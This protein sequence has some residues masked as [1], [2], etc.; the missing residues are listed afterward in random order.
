MKKIFA[1]I[2]CAA[3]VASAAFAAVGCG[4]EDE[5]IS[6]VNS[7]TTSETTSVG[8]DSSTTPVF[9]ITGFSVS[10]TGIVT[11]QTEGTEPCYLYRGETKLTEI[12]VGDDLSALVTQ[13]V[14]TYTVRAGAQSSNGVKLY[15]PTTVTDFSVNGTVIFFTAETGKSYNLLV[16]GENKGVVN[17]GDNIRTYLVGGAYELCIVLEGGTEGDC[18]RLQASSNKVSINAYG[19]NDVEYDTDWLKA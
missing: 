3:L 13:T 14:E 8:G 4:K 9:P 5:P 19:D 7:S 2:V 17:S 16:N 11:Y 15:K 10:E 12:E 18:I 1:T 6:S